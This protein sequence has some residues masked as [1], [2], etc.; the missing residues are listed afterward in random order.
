MEL[1][2]SS[3][4]INFM[5]YRT[6]SI[7]IIGAL[8]LAATFFLVTKGFNYALDF[9]VKDARDTAVRTLFRDLRFQWCHLYYFYR[10]PY[11]QKLHP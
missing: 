6:A 4:N 3:T 10:L 8:C 5:R 11:Y 7:A 1:F 9:G 2:P